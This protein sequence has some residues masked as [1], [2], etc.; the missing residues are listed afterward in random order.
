MTESSNSA[1]GALSSFGLAGKVALITGA[2]SGLGLATARLFAEVGASVIL[3]DVNGDAAGLAAQKLEALAPAMA[4]QMNVAE[5]DSVHG[6]FDQAVQRFGGVDILVN[7]AAYRQKADTM[8]MSV[9]EWDR[10]HAVNTRGT[11]LCIREAVR[12]MRARG[13]GAIVNVSSMSAERPTIFPN[14]HYDSSKAGVDA[15]TR[16]AAVEFGPDNIRVNSVLPGGMDTQGGAQIREAHVNLAGPATMPGRNPLGR[17][18]QPV[19]V[20][21][22]I[23]FLASPAASF[24]TGVQL[25]VDGGFTKG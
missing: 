15:I 5:E 8:T 6:A 18:A 9:A 16:L 11:F 10:M 3:G 24:V 7:N 2:A 17:I 21:R 22:A 13:G 20:A 14:M 25:L 4:V 12:Q 1:I 19:E 23:L